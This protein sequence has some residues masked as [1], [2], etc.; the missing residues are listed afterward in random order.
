MMGPYL[1]LNHRC[2]L[3][4]TV[5][6]FS[7]YSLNTGWRRVCRLHAF[8]G[9]AGS[10]ASVC[11]LG[12]PQEVLSVRESW[13]T[14]HSQSLTR[15]ARSTLSVVWVAPNEW[16]L[17]RH[18]FPDALS[19]S[20]FSNKPWP[21]SEHPH[22]TA[23][24]PHVAVL[25]TMSMCSKPRSAYF[26]SAGPHAACVITCHHLYGRRRYTV[27]SSWCHQAVTM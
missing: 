3:A 19:S 11:V 21:D 15:V 22:Y 7:C 6:Q 1:L 10:Y 12:E 25:T 17:P 26:L 14:F 18:E 8:L 5:H 9:R 13:E 4:Y 16:H 2:K 23:L 27:A 24:R 20:L